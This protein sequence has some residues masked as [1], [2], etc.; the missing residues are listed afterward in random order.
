[1]RLADPKPGLRDASDNF[2]VPLDLVLVVNEVA[3]RLHLAAALQVDR[4]AVP[5][6][7]E[8]LPDRGSRGPVPLDFHLVADAEFA[9]LNLGDLVPVRVLDDER[10]A[11]PHRLA[12]DPEGVIPVLIVDP[13]V[14]A[15]REQLLL[16]LVARPPGHL[17]VLSQKAHVETLR[18]VGK[19]VRER[20]DRNA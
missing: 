15:Y 16:H 5:D 4:E 20:W 19:S 17:I 9:L 3:L 10:L 18:Q 7:D 11:N 12:V 6:A 8:R 2:P 14:V 1:M 13:V